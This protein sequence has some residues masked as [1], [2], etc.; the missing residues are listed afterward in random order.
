MKNTNALFESRTILFNIAIIILGGVMALIGANGETV[1]MLLGGGLVIVIGIIGIGLRIV[2]RMPLSKKGFAK[3]KT[4]IFNSLLGLIGAIE[5]Y[6]GFIQ[7]IFS[8]QE[9][10]GVFMIIIGTGGF[11]LRTMTTA[12]IGD[13]YGH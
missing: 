10:F 7:N 4:I 1:D 9:M 3:S 8:N 6:S 11:I 2:T 5:S 13:D 12:P